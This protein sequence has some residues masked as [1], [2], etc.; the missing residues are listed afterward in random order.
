LGPR[1]SCGEFEIYVWLKEYFGISEEDVQWQDVLS[2]WVGSLDGD[3]EELVEAE[4]KR[5]IAFLQDDSTLTTFLKALLKRYKS[6]AA[7]YPGYLRE[8]P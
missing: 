2:N 5:V 8:K 4:K 7:T 6:S 3:L 1:G